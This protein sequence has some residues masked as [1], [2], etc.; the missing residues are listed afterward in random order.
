MKLAV[1][2]REVCCALCFLAIPAICTSRVTLLPPAT[3]PVELGSTDRDSQL[4]SH[5]EVTCDARGDMPLN[6]AQAA[7]YVTLPAGMPTNGNCIGYWVRFSVISRVSDA[8]GWALQLRDPWQHA[9]LYLLR[10]GV[11]PV[12][13]TGISIPPQDRALPSGGTSLPIYL[14]SGSAKTFYL[15][16]TGDTTRYGESRV[17]AA[18]VI[19]MGNW[20]REQRSATF[21]QG[22]YNGVIAG[23]ALYNLILFVAIQETVY[24]YYVLYVV[25]FGI[26]WI[27]RSGFLYQY[28]WPHHPQWNDLYQPYFAASAILFSVLFVREFLSTR[29]RTP[30]VDLVLRVILGLTAFTGFAGL[31]GNVNLMALPLSVIGLTVSVLYA[32]MGLIALAK[33]YRPARFFLVAWAALLVGNVIYILMFLRLLPMTFL[34]YNAAQAGSAM[35]CILLAFAL[36]DRVNLL[37]RARERRQLEYTH[38]LQEEVRQR[39]RELSEAVEKLQMVSA[40]DPLTGLSNRRHIEA[41]VQ[42]WIADLQ[43]VRIRN[44]PVEPLRHLAVCLAD[45]DHFKGI[46]DELGHAVGDKVLRAAAAT[47]RQNVRATALLARWG[48]EEFLVLD[49]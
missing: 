30:R 5:A 41:A 44:S 46:N 24:L 47:L 13:R 10:D 25:S 34:T 9:D 36:A 31:G 6:A 20:V 21:G 3:P 14:N 38:E 19:P 49:H 28:L 35:E 42:P 48:G 22:I 40:T 2:T 17:V 39:T 37:K 15:H 23:L 26:V 43:R 32:V 11:V 12:E 33:G 7:T 1:T 45:L 16:L 29:K 8:D 4:A 18:T 27:S